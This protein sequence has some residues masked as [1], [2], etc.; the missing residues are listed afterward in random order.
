MGTI[1]QSKRLELNTYHVGIKT[2]IK[3]PKPIKKRPLIQHNH[4]IAKR[5][6]LKNPNQTYQHIIPS[7]L[8]LTK[9]YLKR[10]KTKRLPYINKKT[11]IKNQR[12]YHKPFYKSKTYIIQI[13]LLPR[14][15]NQNDIKI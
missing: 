3:I 13:I 9:P 15:I 6:T 11:L 8:S 4:K 12:P 10:Q 7:K 2:K 5:L 1:N 14:T